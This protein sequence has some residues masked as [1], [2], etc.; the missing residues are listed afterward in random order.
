MLSNEIPARLA[1]GNGRMRSGVSAGAISVTGWP[2]LCASRYPSPVVPH[3]GYEAPPVVMTTDP[4]RYEA[5]TVV[6]MNESPSHSMPVTGSLLLIFTPSFAHS[7]RRTPSTSADFRVAGKTLPL[8]SVIMASPRF[9]K[10]S[11]RVLFGND[12]RA[13]FTNFP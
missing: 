5:E 2:R 13:G 10:N 7:A 9:W 6:T 12:R 1:N 3:W 4:A 11:M 8:P